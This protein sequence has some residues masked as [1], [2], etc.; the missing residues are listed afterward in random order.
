MHDFEVEIDWIGKRKTGNCTTEKLKTTLPEVEEENPVLGDQLKKKL[1]TWKSS[2]F[3]IGLL[4]GV[5][6]R[7][8]RNG[9]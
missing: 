8:S 5:K 3:L 9:S 7:N 4:L 6:S 1:R 2:V